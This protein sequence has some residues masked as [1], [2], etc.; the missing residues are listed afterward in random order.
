[1]LIGPSTPARFTM[2]ARRLIPDPQLQFSASLAATVGLEEAVLIQQLK[3]VYLHQPAV[4]RDGRDW[5]HLSHDYLLNLL[6][7]WD[8][9]TLAR[10]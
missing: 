4:R 10:S 1:M 6:P 7:F 9:E 8:G 5:L 2:S 3:C